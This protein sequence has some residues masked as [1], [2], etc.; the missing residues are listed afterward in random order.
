MRYAIGTPGTPW[1]EAEVEQW[2]RSA[3]YHRSYQGQVVDHLYRISDRFHIDNYGA[4]S[5]DPIRYALFAIKTATPKPELPWVLLTGGVHGYET[6]GVMGA[7]SF[8]VN[9]ADKYQD[10]FNFVV[11]PCVS[12]WGFETINRWNF[13]AIDPNR[14][15]KHGGECEEARCAIDYI[16][17]LDVSFLLHMDLHETTDTDETEFRPALAAKLGQDYIATEIPDGFYLVGDTENP[18]DHFHKAIIDAVEQITHI[19]PCDDEGRLLGDVA[20]QKGVV[21]YACADLGLCTSLTKAT[22]TTT[23]EVYP[24]SGSVTPEGCIKAQVTA[25]EA[26]LDFVISEGV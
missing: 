18:Q 4:L 17:R 3:F 12:P 15:F 16:K 24:D 13:D 25:V 19:A 23:T 5:H 11:L 14:S 7:L 1:G 8:V 2:Q 10:Q 22:Y 26:A 6:S 9:H 21:N 20:R